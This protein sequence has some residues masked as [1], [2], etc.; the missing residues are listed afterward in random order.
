MHLSPALRRALRP[1]VI[2]SQA[3][4]VPVIAPLVILVLGFGLAPKVLLVALVCFFP[5]TINLYDGLRAADP[6]ARRLLRSLAGDA[7]AGAAAGR[8]A[9]RAAGR[10][11]RPEG[12]RRRRR[13]RRRVRRVG[14]RR[15]R[16]RPRAA[17]RQRA[18]SRPRARSPPRS[19]SSCWP[20]PSTAPARCSSGAWSTGPPHRTRRTMTDASPRPRCSSSAARP[21]RRLRREGRARPRHG[22]R[23]R[24]G[25]SA[26]RLMLD[27]FPNADHAG[28]LRRAGEPAPTRRPGSTCEITPPPD[29]VGAA[30]SCCR[31]ARPTSR[32]P[33]SRSCCSRATRARTSSRS[34]RSC[35]SR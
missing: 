11:H 33:T 4:P 1:L 21:A 24:P 34:A 7:L 6:D 17:D 16:P 10:V 5:V 27:Y 25:A 32:S 26:L 3:V 15:A 23:R 22:R 2:G 28:H 29:P 8:G 9:G 20:S 30:A 12:R 19:C 31:R 14:R 35:R 18:S 13:D